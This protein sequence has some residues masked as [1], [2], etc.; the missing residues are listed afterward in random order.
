MRANLVGRSVVSAITQ[1]PASGPLGPLT[2]P[3]ISVS[4]T[5]TAAGD[6]W[7]LSSGAAAARNTA[8]AVVAKNEMMTLRRIGF[9]REPSCSIVPRRWD[10]G[11]WAVSGLADTNAP[12]TCREIAKSASPAGACRKACLEQTERMQ[13]DVTEKIRLPIGHISSSFCAR[14]IDF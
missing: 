9:S 4:P 2:T 3:P 11:K 14:S 8:M 6:C 12:R 13:T 7:A 10:L 5:V 1:T